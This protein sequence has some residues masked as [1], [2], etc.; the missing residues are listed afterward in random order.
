MIHVLL[1]MSREIIISL[2]LVF[3][4]ELPVSR[5]GPGGHGSGAEVRIFSGLRRKLQTHGGDVSFS[6][7][8]HIPV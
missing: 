1:K 8:N 5:P 4:F 3:W 7:R 2:T 6:N